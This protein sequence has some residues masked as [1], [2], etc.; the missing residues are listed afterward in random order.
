MPVFAQDLPTSWQQ[1]TSVAAVKLVIREKFGNQKYD[2]TF[3]VTAP[4]G[5]KFSRSVEVLPE[6]WGVVFF[7]HD[8]DGADEIAGKYKWVA[9]VNGEKVIGGS[10]TSELGEK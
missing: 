5:K 7:P 8:F 9:S 10:F 2:A 3:V 6:E 4:D 1:S